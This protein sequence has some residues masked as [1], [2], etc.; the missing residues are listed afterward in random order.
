MSALHPLLERAFSL[1]RPSPP[2]VSPG[3]EERVIRGWKAALPLPEP[4]ADFR[5]ALA[6]ACILLF[7]S[8]AACYGFLT[9]SADPLL[10][11]ANSAV[12]SSL[13]P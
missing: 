5:L 2:S 3:L 6:F 1:A 9:P 4:L 13:Q 8:F 10:I 11:L 7:V 12:Q